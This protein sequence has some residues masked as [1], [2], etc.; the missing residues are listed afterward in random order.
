MLRS[1][2]IVAFSL[3]VS[4]F[5]VAC[6]QSQNTKETL[7]HGG[8]IRIYLAADA[9]GVAVNSN[10]LVDFG[11]PM[12]PDSFDG[13]VEF[14]N[15]ATGQN[16]RNEGSFAEDN[17]T[18]VV[19]FP[20]KLLYNTT[21]RLTLNTGITYADGT[22]LPTAFVYEF[23]TSSTTDTTA[24]T[25]TAYYDDQNRT[26]FSAIKLQ[27]NEYIDTTTLNTSNVK[28][29]QS[30]SDIGANVLISANQALINPAQALL[31]G[32]S[33]TLTVTGVK[34]LAGNV[35]ADLSLTFQGKAAI[36]A[37]TQL[38]NP[39]G[40][41]HLALSTITLP[42]LLIKSA[43]ATDINTSRLTS[44]GTIY[45]DTINYSDL[46]TTLA[47]EAEGNK[48]YRLATDGTF[49]Y[50]QAFDSDAS[51]LLNFTSSYT[52]SNLS[53][54][55]VS[56]NYVCYLE[57]NVSEAVFLTRVSDT[58]FSNHGLYTLPGLG[59]S[60]T[61]DNTKG[62][63]AVGSDTRI[64]LVD[65]SNTTTPNTKATISTATINALHIEGNTLFALE[66]NNTLNIY[67]IS[68]PS[69]PNAHSSFSLG[70]NYDK[71][72][73][74]GHFVY[75]SAQ[76]SSAV[77][78]VDVSDFKNPRIYYDLP[79]ASNVSDIAISAIAPIST[80]L[81]ANTTTLIVGHDNT[82]VSLESFDI[83]ALSTLHANHYNYTN[84]NYAYT[85]TQR[86][87]Y[88][89]V[90]GSDSID[91]FKEND[92]NT[93][94]LFSLPVVQ[95]VYALQEYDDNV[96]NKNLLIVGFKNL[97]V[98]L[99]DITG[100]TAAPTGLV[101]VAT[102][103]TLGSVYSLYAIANRLYIGSSSG[104]YSYD[105][106]NIVAPTLL[107]SDTTLT[108][109]SSIANNP[110]TWL[111]LGHFDGN[112]SK[113]GEGNFTLA[114]T[115][116]TADIPRH[117]EPDDPSYPGVLF[118]SEGASGIEVLDL[119]NDTMS[120]QVKTAGFAMKSE[121]HLSSGGLARLYVADYIGISEL[122]DSTSSV[123]MANLSL[124][125]FTPTNFRVYDVTT[126]SNYPSSNLLLGVASNTNL[127]RVYTKKV[128]AK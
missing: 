66:N 102:L 76:T 56:Q 44:S 87:S 16:V 35:A 52:D 85:A 93:Q 28:I 38:S 58:N 14:I 48:T 50:I 3:F 114:A 49:T 117:L 9:T 101:P 4:L 18:A 118:I 6:T 81:D 29:T 27:S 96:T 40:V 15:V 36:T 63:A 104:F 69:N 111:Y 62:I 83:S 33:Y 30:S 82:T 108:N 103:P 95:P 23:T 73:V 67:D 72:K 100:G 106:T 46:N 128:I 121:F 116:A 80:F 89:Y 47:L 19:T 21:Y 34:D 41:K 126:S 61:I 112:I 105:I 42:D 53:D 26:P 86:G 97:G 99:F 54:F 31:P 78:I 1:I 68:D 13:N 17:I 79:T 109:I 22:S 2:F 107:N 51:T 122:I 90:G 127:F 10:M 20:D 125:S 74:S 65:I 124:R 60:C 88:Y 43:S 37:S 64:D 92:F 115:I 84:S 59:R 11:V 12:N 91:I 32:V 98:M 120:A 57:N 39:S 110:G 119:S 45:L 75:L 94:A 7:L 55:F 70:A 113:I 71:M 24:P 77:K 123:T 25:L 8:D 5:F